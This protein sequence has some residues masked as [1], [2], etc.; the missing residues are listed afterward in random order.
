MIVD[1]AIY[2]DGLR[3]VEPRS[4]RET[5]EALRERRGVAWIGLYKPTGGEFASVAE[6][7][8][9]HE[10]AVEDAIQAHQRPKLERYGDTLFAV[11]R[12]ARYLDAPEEVEFGE[13]HVF[14]GE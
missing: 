1:N 9:L 8:G 5:Y 10:L 11:L 6:E 12:P 14:V 3:S 13:I 7:F 4:L 2:V